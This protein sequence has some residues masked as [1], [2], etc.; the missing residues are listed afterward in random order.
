MDLLSCP[1]CNQEQI[2]NKDNYCSFCFAPFDD[3]T[4]DKRPPGKK[5]KFTRRK[6][7]QE[8]QTNNIR[9]VLFP[10]VIVEFIAIL[11]FRINIVDDTFPIKFLGFSFI[12]SVF[13]SIGFYIKFY[14]R[15]F[16]LTDFI[17]R[18]DPKLKTF[19]CLY[20]SSVFSLLL[21]FF[22]LDA[23]LIIFPDQDYKV[24]V[25]ESWVING[26]SPSYHLSVSSWRKESQEPINLLI[27][28]DLW[29]QIGPG[30]ILI[31]KVRHGGLGIERVRS[32]KQVY[33]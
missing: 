8:D 21:T 15:K 32:I 25:L 20:F 31:I 23:T 11:F 9:F 30:A 19:F 24:S 12:L 4:H 13:T 33:H 14:G 22:I 3:N 29:S 17:G 7:I 5:S 2:R 6:I 16:K 26:K 28:R 1:K 27:N 18:E 10:F